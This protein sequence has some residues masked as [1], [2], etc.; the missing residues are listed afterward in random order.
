[1]LIVELR[2]DLVPEVEFDRVRTELFVEEPSGTGTTA[3]I[4]EVEVLEG[5]YSAGIRVAEFDRV[6]DGA[7]VVRVQLTDAG[8]LVTS[9]TIRLD[10]SDTLAI[11]VV[12]TRSCG[13]VVCPGPG[14]SPD[15]VSC[16]GGRC[17]EAG[18]VRGDEPECGTAE[19]TSAS[20]CP[21]PSASCASAVCVEGLCVDMLDDGA[22]EAGQRCH[23]ERSCVDPSADLTNF[24]LRLGLGGVEGHALLGSP[25]E[26]SLDVFTI[27]MWVKRTGPGDPTDSG[28]VGD[29]LNPAIPLFTKGKGDRDGE[30]AADINYFVGLANDV[31]YVLA[32]DFEEGAGGDLSANHPV[33]ATTSTIANEWHHVAVTYDG[34]VM[35]LYLDGVMDGR[36]DVGPAPP[37]SASQVEAAIGAAARLD[38]GVDGNFEGLLDELRVWGR[39]RTEAEINETMNVAIVTDPDLR[40][41]FGFDEGTGET[42]TDSHAGIVGRLVSPGLGFGFDEDVPFP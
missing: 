26:L 4:S 10:V 12:I 3:R 9:R 11:P 16:V 42:I 39:A 38:G 19:C 27:E 36:A 23:P 30:E 18:C 13:G 41:R 14:D 6:E 33:W 5:D 31:G 22:C 20:D 40:C 8:D 15:A 21:A 25:D 28:N 37:A 34:S 35:R 1:M 24:S 32:A 2:T 7:Y 29:A 17:Q